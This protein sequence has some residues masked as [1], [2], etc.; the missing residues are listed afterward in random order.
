MWINSMQELNWREESGGHVIHLS[1][2]CICSDHVD[3]KMMEKM[4]HETG[5]RLCH[6]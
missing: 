6:I 4:K 2:S 1:T 3:G 5:D